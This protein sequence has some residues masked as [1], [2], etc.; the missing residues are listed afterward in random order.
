MRKNYIFKRIYSFDGKKV[1][2][3]ISKIPWDIGKTVQE[4]LKA[5]IN[6]IRAIKP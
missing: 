3:S 6:E 4:K 5:V 2:N 1:E